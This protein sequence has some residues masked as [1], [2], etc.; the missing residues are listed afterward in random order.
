MKPSMTLMETRQYIST[1]CVFFEG[2][3]CQTVCN[4]PNWTQFNKVRVFLVFSVVIKSKLGAISHTGCNIP[5]CVQFL[6][7]RVQFLPNR[8]QFLPN[9][10]GGWQGEGKV[11]ASVV[12]SVR[13]G[14]FP[15]GGWQGEG[16]VVASVVGNVWGG[17]TKFSREEVR[18]FPNWVHG[19]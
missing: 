10:D 6:P 15:T 12:G 19:M 14:S 1:G 18:R 9:R 3:F 17:G 13:G 7:I 8:V 11:V 5:Y 4:F 16:K 2:N